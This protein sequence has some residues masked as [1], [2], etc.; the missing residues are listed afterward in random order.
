MSSKNK[1][2]TLFALKIS[3]IFWA[4]LRFTNLITLYVART[5][6]MAHNSL[7]TLST[8]TWHPPL[9]LGIRLSCELIRTLWLFVPIEILNNMFYNDFPS[10]FEKMVQADQLFDQGSHL[11]NIHEKIK[12]TYVYK[13]DKIYFLSIH[14]QTISIYYEIILRIVCRFRLKKLQLSF[15]FLSQFNLTFFL[16]NSIT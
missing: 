6:S 2:S 9:G 10:I 7:T 1:N 13:I 15:D 11:K 16:W 12:S 3:L 8:Q 14:N 5:F 4:M